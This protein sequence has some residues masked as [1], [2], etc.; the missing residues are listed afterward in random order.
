MAGLRRY[1]ATD[2]GWRQVIDHPESW[3]ETS[4]TGMFTYAM[5]RGVNEGWLDASYAADARKGWALLTTKVLPTGST[6]DTCPATGPG[7]L[8]HYLKRPRI[9]DDPHSFGPILLAGA[10]IIRLNR[11]AP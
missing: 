5:A 9:T 11:A 8:E 4:C 2:G 3:S 1:Q 7:K 6:I 10:E